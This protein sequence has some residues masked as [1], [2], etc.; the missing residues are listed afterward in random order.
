[1]ARKSNESIT[2]KLAAL[3]TELAEVNR[4]I[5][6]RAVDNESTA[7]VRVRRAKLERAIEELREAAGQAEDD[8]QRGVAEK[9]ADLAQTFAEAA[10]RVVADRMM[11]LQ[12]PKRKQ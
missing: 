10:E 9:M 6:R 11:L 2:D 3:N 5:K 12:M 7:V 1:M 4:L 8:E